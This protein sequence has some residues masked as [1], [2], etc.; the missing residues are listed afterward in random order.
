MINKI[1]PV[2]FMVM[3]PVVGAP[4]YPNA[5]SATMTISAE[6]QADLLYM[7]EE[8]KLARDTYLTLSEDWDLAV[9]SNIAGSEQK[10]MDALLKLLKTYNLPDP[11]ASTA[12]GEF[13]NTTLQNL[14]NTLLAMGKQSSLNA[15]KVGGIIEETDM[16]DI[17]A[18]IERS[19]K[20]DIDLVY[21]S[22]VCGSRNHLR[23]FA[24]N[25]V[26]ATGVAYVAQVI[27]QTEVDQIL[28]S[29]ME[30]CGK[31]K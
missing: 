21:E 25:I 1:I 23:S 16:R 9:L 11:A 10:H 27:S 3:L 5:Y 20:E 22:L 2:L 12:I 31:N 4:F 26:A 28:Q 19:K 17:N 30:K 15:L 6:E 8:E 13:T 18:A 24:Q 14:Y 29:P 7:R